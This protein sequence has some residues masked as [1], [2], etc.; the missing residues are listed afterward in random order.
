[1]CPRTTLECALLGIIDYATR[2]T[3]E[4]LMNRSLPLGEAVVDSGRDWATSLC[5]PVG[6]EVC[7]K[8]LS[9]KS[10]DHVMIIV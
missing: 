1:M 2:V 4:V 8:T 6:I 5:S 9:E 7:L 10:V 3:D